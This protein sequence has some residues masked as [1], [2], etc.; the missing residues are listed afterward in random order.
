MFILIKCGGTDQIVINPNC[1]FINFDLYLREKLKELGCDLET[2]EII[3]LCEISGQFAM[4]GLRKLKRYAR[5]S[6]IVKYGE[7]YVPVIVELNSDDDLCGYRF[8]FPTDQDTGSKFN[9]YN[10]L[11]TRL[12]K[13]KVKI[14]KQRNAAKESESSTLLGVKKGGLDGKGS[15][16]RIKINK[17]PRK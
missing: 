12:N 11:I 6:D 1:P 9:L 3:E 13:A 2:N 17:S 16:S 4:R 7:T 14:A 5:V 10:K 15:P 8:L